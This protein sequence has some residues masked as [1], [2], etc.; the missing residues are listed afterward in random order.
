MRF[1]C[2]RTYFWHCFS[3]VLD[4][5]EITHLSVI[6]GS[7]I[8]E[9]NPAII[10]CKV[11]SYPLSKVDWTYED[12]TLNEGNN[13]V[14]QSN[15]T[16]Q[17]AKC[18]D[19]GFY[20]CTATNIINMESY[21]D[22]KVV[23]LSVRCKYIILTFISSIKHKRQIYYTTLDLSFA[24]VTYFIEVPTCSIVFLVIRLSRDEQVHLLSR[25][26]QQNL[27]SLES[28]IYSFNPFRVTFQRKLDAFVTNIIAITKICRNILRLR[29]HE[30]IYPISYKSVKYYWREHE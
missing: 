18:V 22:K 23:Q 1:D 29:W 30:H 5:P 14:L 25:N 27:I 9:N 2:T 16:I 24:H 17:R 26:W 20:M 19:T 12:K 7:E 21:S 11:E 8:V 13:L 10:Q 6:D 15:Y 4:N 28:N 3:L